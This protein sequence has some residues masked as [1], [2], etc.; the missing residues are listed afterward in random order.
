MIKKIWEQND[1]KKGGHSVWEEWFVQ[2]I[3]EMLLHRTPLTCISANILTVVELLHLNNMD[4]V[5]EL[6]EITFIRK[7][8][9]IL[10]VV[11]KTIAA[12]QLASVNEYKQLFTDG[13]SRRQTAIQNAVVGILTDGGY[14]MITLSSGILLENE[15]SKS[16]TASITCTF[17]EGRSLLKKWR[18]ITSQLY[19]GREDLLQ[20]IPAADDLSLAKLAKGGLINTYQANAAQ[21]YSRNLLKKFGRKLWHRAYRS[22]KSRHLKETAGITCAMC[23]LVL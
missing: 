14:K 17:E 16:V 23:G 15:T 6:P 3:L 10:T 11:T 18:D 9:S 1:S 19:P 2:M 7:C 5:K 13:R 4:I 21:G 8:R 20:L 22:Q 12:Y